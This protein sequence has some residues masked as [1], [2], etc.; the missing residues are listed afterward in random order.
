MK[1]LIPALATAVVLMTAQSHAAT[2]KFAFQGDVQSLDPHG[3]NETFT[4]G[5]LGN[6]YEGLT[7]YDKDLKVEPG[8]AT[9]WKNTSPTT[10]TFHLRKDVKFHN[11][12]PFTAD[13][14]VFSWKRTLTPGSDMKGYGGQIKSIKVDDPYTIEITTPV[15]DPI[16]PR[17]LVYLYIMDKKWADANKATEATSPSDADKSSTYASTHENG[18]GPFEVVSRQ[19]DVKTVMKRFK[20]YW[21]KI[22][23]NVDEVIFTPISQDATRTAALL[24]GDIDLAYPLPVQDWPRLKSTQGVKALTGAE[25]RTIFLGMDQFRDQ[26]LYS[27]IKGKNPLK[28]KR[29]RE[30][31]AHAIDMKTIDKKIMRGAATPTG[32]LVGPQ[33]NGFDKALNEPYK[34]DPALSKKLLK[35]AGYPNGFELGM[36]C[37]N[38]RYVNDAL[39]CQAA[40]GYL[41]RVGIKIQLNAQPK[42]KYFAKVSPQNGND[43]SFYM[44]GWS[45]STIDAENAIQNLVVTF[46]KNGDDGQFNYGHYSNP[47]IDALSKKIQV[48]TDPKKRQ[49]MLDEAFKLLK[50]DYGYLPVHQQPLSWGVRDGIKVAQ[51]ADNVLDLRDVV[52]GGK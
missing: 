34:Y 49:Q 27:N 9:S 43:T 16:L 47:K 23:G 29:V 51:R 20:D 6:M 11:G 50:D 18:T 36:D 28:D 31:M 13:D 45:P 4:L 44:L 42:S 1:K 33:I 48:E 7:H 2:F 15:P 32:L 37:P 30:A 3:L 35:E 14:V 5:F 25:I 19:A 12:D 17:D 52:V 26:L 24:S 46:T 21:G 39:V 41:A 22:P 8:L 10:W 38:N 40:A